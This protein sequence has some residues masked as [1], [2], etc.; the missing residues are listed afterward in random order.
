M[1]FPGKLLQE[2]E[3]LALDL[4]PHWRFLLRPALALAGAVAASVLAAV[5]G[6][7]DPV[8]LLLAAVTL[9]VLAWFVGRYLR[10]A[11]TSFVV[12]SD[13]LISR[14]GVLAKRGME[15]P[16]ERVNTVFSHQT[17]LERLLRCGDLTIESGGEQGQ[18][19]LADI[20]RPADVQSEISRRIEANHARLGRATP[21]TAPSIPDQLERL[22]DLRRRGVVTQAEFDAKKAHLLERM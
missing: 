18:Q 4:R 12:T 2:G 1:A 14:S 9:A 8:L 10:W 16:L 19:H 15:I 5:A 3:E 7:P 13:R 21:A 17:L 6:A 22:D 20:P 11:S